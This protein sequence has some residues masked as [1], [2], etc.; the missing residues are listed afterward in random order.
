MNEKSNQTKTA[1]FGAGCFWGV[2]EI[3]RQLPGVVETIVGYAGGEMHK[4]TYEDVCTGR[5]NHAEVV[6][7][8]YDPAIVSYDKL[9][10]VFWK[11]HNPTTLNRQGPDVGTQYRSVIFYYDHEQKAA[12]EKSKQELEE[13]KIFANPVVTQIIIAPPFYEAEDY[14]QKYFFKRG[15]APTCHL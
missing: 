15:I 5:T 9:L 10:D 8:E 1:L 14:H 2:E 12:A 11:N 13:S 3:F 7:V 4:P 6:R